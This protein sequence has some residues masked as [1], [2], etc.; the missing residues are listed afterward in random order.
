M[1]KYGLLFYNKLKFFFCFWKKVFLESL[2]YNK[3]K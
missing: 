3:Q 2:T 1:K